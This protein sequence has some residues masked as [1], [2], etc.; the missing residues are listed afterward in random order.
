MNK[1]NYNRYISS[2]IHTALRDIFG[3]TII[4][5]FRIFKNSHFSLI[6]L[7]LTIQNNVEKMDGSLYLARIILYDKHP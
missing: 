4:K 5:I 7:Y 1:L 2:K 3:F 6:I